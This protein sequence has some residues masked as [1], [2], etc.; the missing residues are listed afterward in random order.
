MGIIWGLY[1]KFS[2]APIFIVTLILG[3]VYLRIGK[4]R[5][6]LNVFTRIIAIFGIACVLGNL[7]IIKLNNEYESVYKQNTKFTEYA[8]V[9]SEE[10]QAEYKKEYKIRVIGNSSLKNK[11]FIL[12]VSKNSKFNLKFGD[13]IKINGEY[14]KPAVL[15]N[16]GGFDYSNY[17]K[18]KQIY[19]ICGKE[20]K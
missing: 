18:S 16:Y 5:R 15:R 4:Y 12:R 20:S 13:L 11:K 19:G 7:C 17:L 1:I 3:I 10:K 2:I 9:V 8:V 6:I 14:I